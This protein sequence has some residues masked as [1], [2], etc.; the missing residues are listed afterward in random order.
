MLTSS[1]APGLD[2]GPLRS[3][4]SAMLCR[5]RSTEN[6]PCRSVSVEAED[7]FLAEHG[8]EQVKMTCQVL[9]RLEPQGHDLAAR[10]TDRTVRLEQVTL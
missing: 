5:G 2:S 3:S 8:L 4:C 7:I 10:I 1:S 6:T 9:G